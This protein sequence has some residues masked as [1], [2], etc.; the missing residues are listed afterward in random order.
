MATKTS[1]TPTK[2]EK[3]A[4]AKAAVKTAVKSAA[5]PAEKPAEKA[6]AKKTS[7]KT[8]VKNAD[9]KP[10][11]QAIVIKTGATPSEKSA[12]A[13]KAKKVSQISEHQQRLN[14]KIR[15]LEHLSKE[16]GYL[17]NQDINKYLTE[18]LSRP[19]NTKTSVTFWSL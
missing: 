11:P 6:A 9:K 10:S 15:Q 4:K 17:T 1:K 12:E 8:V 7:V 13:K 18:I 19:K 16:K 2:S 14:E 5:K 3:T